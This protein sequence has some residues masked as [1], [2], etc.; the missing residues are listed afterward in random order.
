MAT[1]R[2]ASTIDLL[3]PNAKAVSTTT[4]LAKPVQITKDQLTDPDE[5]AKQ[6]NAMNL[7]VAQVSQAQRAHPEQAP[8]TFKNVTCGTGGTKTKPLG[9]GFGR[10][11]E[12]IVTK[13]KGSG[14]TAGHSLVCDEDD[15]ATA[16]T[17]DDTIC[18]R[19]YVAGTANIRV[20]PGA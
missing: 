9:H 7:V 10:H 5:H 1:P 8:I 14:T 3:T 16:I 4:A 2:I 13:W 19:S 12:Y 15:G 18:F 20:Y 11:A 6:L 17:N